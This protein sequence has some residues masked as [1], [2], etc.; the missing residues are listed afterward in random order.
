[1]ESDGAGFRTFR[2]AGMFGHDAAVQPDGDLVVTGGNVHRVPVV[3]VLGVLGGV[4]ETV[5]AARG[6]RVGVAI[7]DLDLVADFGRRLGVIGRRDDGP[8]G[9]RGV[10]D[11]DAAVAGGLGPVF[12]VE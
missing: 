3:V 4:D 11:G 12:E 8:F 7:I 10:A 2:I 9:A 6:V 5:E 1:M